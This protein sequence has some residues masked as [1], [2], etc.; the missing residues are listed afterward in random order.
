[1]PL[2]RTHRY[3]S[4]DETKPILHAGLHAEEPEVRKAAELARENLLQMGRF[5]FLEVN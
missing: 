5:D 4:V 1:M 3:I 2:A